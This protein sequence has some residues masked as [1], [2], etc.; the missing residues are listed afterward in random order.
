MGIEIKVSSQSS[1]LESTAPV[2]DTDYALLRA[3]INDTQEK[4]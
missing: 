3:A 1:D 4:N 2:V